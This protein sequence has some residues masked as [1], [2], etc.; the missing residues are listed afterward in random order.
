MTFVSVLPVPVLSFF[1]MCMNII[2]IIC[3]SNNFPIPYKHI[4]KETKVFEWYDKNTLVLWANWQEVNFRHV[5]SCQ[6]AVHYALSWYFIICQWV[7][8]VRAHTHLTLKLLLVVEILCL[9]PTYAVQLPQNTHI[10]RSEHKF[11]EYDRSIVLQFANRL[12]RHGLLAYRLQWEFSTFGEG[13]Q[14]SGFP[15]VHDQLFLSFLNSS[16]KKNIFSTY[17]PW[18]WWWNSSST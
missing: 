6:V 1:M 15:F 9:S 17:S 2:I 12:F 3:T 13:R 10:K 16:R 18:I 5:G 4:I 8:S 14:I 7:S 11:D